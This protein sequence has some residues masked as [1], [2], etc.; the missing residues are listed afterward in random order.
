MLKLKKLSNKKLE[1]MQ[2]ISNNSIENKNFKNSKLI[3][4]IYKILFIKIRYF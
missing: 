4:I 1:K 3:S 2:K